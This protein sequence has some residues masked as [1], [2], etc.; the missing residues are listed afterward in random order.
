MSSNGTDEQDEAGFVSIEVAISW[1]ITVVC[2][3]GIALNASLVYVTVKSKSIHSKCNVLIALYA[4]FAIFLHIGFCV[5]IVIFLSGINSITLGTCFW[6]Q[7]INGSASVMCIV[8]Q[9]CIGMER[10]MAVS[11]PIWYNMSGKHSV[12]KVLLIICSIKVILDRCVIYY[13]CSKHWESL[14]RCDLGD[15]SNQPETTD[16]SVYN[17]LIIVVAEVL[18]YAMLW[19]IS[20]W[21][22][23]Q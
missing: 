23:G 12:F 19:L 20:W 17:M 1:I 16:Y 13:G 15:L 8:L 14:V 5:K 9:L 3:F 7:F 10:L 2:F 4:F 11:F 18:C 6:I 22:K 21:R